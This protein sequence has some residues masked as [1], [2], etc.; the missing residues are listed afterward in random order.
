MLGYSYDGD[1]VRSTTIGPVSNP[2]SDRKL[3]L[4]GA[5]L[6]PIAFTLLLICAFCY[7]HY[8]CRPRPTNR[9]LAKVYP[10]ITRLSSSLWFFFCL[11]YF[12]GT[13]TNISK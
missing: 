13:S 8:K 2:T 4:I 1:F 6:G 9:T 11:G 7:F 10:L 12:K 3:W 5:I